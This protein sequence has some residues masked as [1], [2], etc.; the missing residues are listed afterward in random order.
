M[1]SFDG[2]IEV[3]ISIVLDY[4]LAI[5]NL[6]DENIAIVDFTFLV[7]LD[8]ISPATQVDWMG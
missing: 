6:I 8:D 5:F 3:K 2:E 1:A 4:N 7:L